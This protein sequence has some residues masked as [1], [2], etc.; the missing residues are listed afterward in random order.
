MNDKVK[1]FFPKVLNRLAHEKNRIWEHLPV[2]KISLWGMGRVPSKEEFVKRLKEMLGDITHELIVIASFEE[3]SSIIDAANH[4]LNHEFDHLGSG[5]VKVEPLIWNSDLRTSFK[6]PENKIC[7]KLRGFTQKGSDIKSPWELSRCP[8]F[9][10]LGEAYLLTG[11]EKYAQEIVDEMIHWIN[12]NPLMYSV[13]WTCAMEAAIRAVNW[14][15]SLDMIAGSLALTDDLIE[16]VYKSL[17]QHG[18]Y[19]INHK[20]KIIPYSNNHYYSDLV[21]L[22]FIG[23]FFINTQTGLRWY[24]Y[25]LKKYYKETLIQFLPSGVNYEKSVSYHRLMTELA[26]YPYYMLNRIGVEIPQ[27]ISERI[28]SAI[29]YIKNYTMPNGNAPM[30]AD[31]DD[32]RLLPFVPRNMREHSYLATENS[33]EQRLGSLGAISLTANNSCDD[34]NLFSDAKIAVIK[35]NDCYLMVTAADRWR[36]DKDNGSY[37]GSHL[38][39]DLLSFVLTVGQEEVFVDPG[40]YVYTSDIHKH[41]EFRKTA[42]HNTIVVDNEEQHLRDKEA[43][44]MM[45]YNSTSK[46]LSLF[47]AGEGIKCEGEYNTHLGGFSHKRS[48]L[49]KNKNLEIIDVL[50][51]KGFG[52]EMTFYLHLA[53]NI[54]PQVVDGAVCFYLNEYRFKVF[55]NSHEADDSIQ[56][57]DDTFSP[58]FGVIQ[59]SKTILYH[60]TFENQMCINTKIQWERK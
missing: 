45:K 25:S 54:S 20:E 2:E 60:N 52:H 10:W 4:A 9:L 8:H 26:L 49:L 46:P 16:K 19:I 11:D 6:W 59:K 39:N 27:E 14:L 55:I 41:Q 23:R 12:H 3:K 48:F 18:F 17:Y 42:K 38:H 21:G 33:L 40:A 28:R 24:K 50:S 47:S 43:P 36:Y 51:K 13:N 15:Y 35:K 57:I 22:L 7:Y 53:P 29:G 5:Y 32:G 30:I 34:T 1:Y 44:F 58:S 37:I 56:I 31:N